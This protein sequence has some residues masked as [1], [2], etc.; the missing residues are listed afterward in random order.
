MKL[1]TTIAIKKQTRDKIA[2]IGKKDQTFDQIIVELLK[3]WNEEN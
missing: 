1:L 2:S 3:K